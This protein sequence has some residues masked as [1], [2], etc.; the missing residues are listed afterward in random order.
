[1][2]SSN[3]SPCWLCTLQRNL[4]SGPFWSTGAAAEGQLGAK[5]IWEAGPS[6]D[7]AAWPGAG[8]D[9]ALGMHQP[10]AQLLIHTKLFF[11]FLNPLLLCWSTT[12]DFSCWLAPREQPALDTGSLL[13][14][15]LC[16]HAHSST[17][18]KILAS[19]RSPRPDELHEKARGSFSEASLCSRHTA[20]LL[21]C[22][23]SF[24][25]NKT[26]RANSTQSKNKRQGEKA[27]A[28][29]SLNRSPNHGIHKYQVSS[30]CDPWCSGH[31]CPSVTQKCHLFSTTAFPK[32]QP[33]NICTR[34]AHRGL[35]GGC[36]GISMLFTVLSIREIPVTTR[37]W[38]KPTLTTTFSAAQALNAVQRPSYLPAS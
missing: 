28:K 22:F 31:T 34:L 35:S 3:S 30:A 27:E 7:E 21:N 32:I 11:F 6:T 16:L 36:G 15:L 4:S 5:Q 33:R 2:S 24:C 13:P 8:G 29:I 14:L 9:E 1:M 20:F 38:Q 23:K 37:S 10:Q 19:N 12:G 17:V 25:F 18:L 26:H